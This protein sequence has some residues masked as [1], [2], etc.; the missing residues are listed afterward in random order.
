MSTVRKNGVDQG[1]FVKISAC[2]I[3]IEE[4]LLIFLAW[5]IEFP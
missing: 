2:F 4:V 3:Q 1:S 5:I